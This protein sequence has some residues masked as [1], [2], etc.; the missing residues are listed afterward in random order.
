MRFLAL[1]I[2]LI[3]CTS[4]PEPQQTEGKQAHAEAPKVD[5]KAISKTIQKHRKYMSHCYGKTITKKGNARI[6][7]LTY[8]E[9]SIGPDGRAKNP[10]M[11]PEKSSLKNPALNAC[12]FEGITSWDFPVD[13]TGKEITVIY[14]FRFNA[15]PPRNMQKKLDMFENLRSRQ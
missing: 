8:V 10:K 11:V 3:G 2:L 6:K 13:P 5:R 4:T 12:L 7:G 9:F 14:P 1:L 15:K